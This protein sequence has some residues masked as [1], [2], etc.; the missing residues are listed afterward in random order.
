MSAG[1]LAHAQPVAGAGTGRALAAS[2]A[3][4]APGALFV[5]GLLLRL[6]ELDRVLPNE[7]EARQA[8]AAWSVLQPQLPGAPPLPESPLLLAL[9]AALFSVFGAGEVTA[10]LPVALVGA[11]LPLA[12]LL[13][14]DVLG[15]GR[16]MAC[17]VLLAASPVL[18]LA[19]RQSAPAV[20]STGLAALLLWGLLRYV[21]TRQAPYAVLVTALAAALALLSEA[22]GI[23]LLLLLC[24]SLF[25]ALQW[26][27]R[28]GAQPTAR[29]LLRSW[30]V[31]A[32]L[33]PAL[34]LVFLVAT[35]FMLRPDGLAAIGE[36]LAAF[37]RGF[38]TPA[39]GGV[40]AHALQAV[41][42]YEPLLLLLALLRL[43]QLRGRPLAFVDRCLLVWASL[44]LPATLLWRGAGPAHALWLSVPLV[45][46]AGGLLAE[47]YASRREEPALPL[48]AAALA[49]A[50]GFALSA[51]FSLHLQGW[52][53]STPQSP[54]AAFHL[55]WMALALA[56]LTAGTWWL[57]LERSRPVA[58]RACGSG[59][60]ALA[61]VASLGSGWRAAVVRA[62]DAQEL[63]Q[64]QPT[65][66][67]AWL[68]RDSLQELAQREHGGFPQL[69]LAAQTGD[70]ALVRWLLRDF[71]R[72][73]VIARVSDGRGAEALLLPWSDEPPPLAG[74][75][76]GQDFVIRRVRSAAAPGP[77][78]AWLPAQHTRAAPEERLVLWLRRDLYDG[79]TQNR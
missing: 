47:L 8:L 26:P 66:R 34:L 16:S 19:S 37:L 73:R 45:G 52:A 9:Q 10:R 33:P 44:A 1:A 11:L 5:L 3:W 13:L 14:R 38:V 61:L 4:L 31:E 77:L 27:R 36:L 50:A 43:L 29:D 41:L 79:A 65:A 57:A 15:R 22:G 20:L 42:F 74:A 76:A 53:R 25:L 67:E 51:L 23:V 63:W 71:A 12:P 69:E 78:T 18:L 72:L 35:L 24:G 60:L 54:A 40:A 7:Q 46:L 62:D 59:V 30:P 56:L 21:N 64:V 70:Q 75:Y 32:A 2:S 39:P 68:L 48:W 49:G 17:C 6:A 58:L 55:A 28:G